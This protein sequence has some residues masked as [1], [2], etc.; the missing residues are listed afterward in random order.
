MYKKD[1]YRILGVNNDATE[2]EIKKSYIV[3]ERKLG[4]F[5]KV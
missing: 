3:S 4:F 2:D 5:I 1:N